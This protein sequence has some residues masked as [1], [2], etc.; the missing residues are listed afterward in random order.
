M[1]LP[2]LTNHLPGIGG[3]IRQRLEDFQVRELPLYEAGGHGTH[4][5][6]TVRKAG[7]PTTA[8]V[9]RIARH[10]GV[11]P[12]EIGFA[13][14]KDA[15]ALTWQRMSLEHADPQRFQSL[16]DPCIGIS[17]ITRHTNKL[18]AGHLAGNRF[19]IR[20]RGVGQEHLEAA[21]AALDVLIARGVPNY[22]GP[23]RFGARQDTHLLGRAMV[24]GGL[25]EFVALLLGRSRPDDPPDCKAARDAFDAGFLQRAL[26]LWPRH[27]RDQRKALAAYKKKRRPMQ[28]LLAVDK[29]MRR[30]FVSA[31]QSHMFNT[32]LARRLESLDRVLEG[33]LAQKTDTGGVFYVEGAAT[34][35]PRADRFEISPTGPLFGYRSSLARGEP[36]YL[37]QQALQESGVDLEAFR[38]LKPM[39]VQG[40]RRPLRFRLI[41]PGLDAGSDEHG[42]FIELAF[43]AP[44]G[45]YATV[46]L[47]EIMK[48]A[49]HEPGEIQAADEAEDKTLG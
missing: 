41:E 28:A 43:T 17:D 18:R 24:A 6:F 9:E 13:G 44:A 3:S 4:V 25:E 2:Y 38:G 5:Y 26:D 21:R 29:R 20:I 33:D 37:E 31:F 10:M 48:T 27:Y 22:F 12:H 16:R 39:K 36:G 8:A 42:S 32:V 49:A 23:Q 35:Q 45:A 15:Q 47:G 19:A 11:H 7:L 34:E 46:A 30:L 14:L 40:S 1:N